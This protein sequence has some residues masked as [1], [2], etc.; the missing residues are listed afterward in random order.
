MVSDMAGDRQL[1]ILI[2]DPHE[3]AAGSLAELLR[4]Y[5]HDATVVR[6]GEEALVSAAESPPDV[7]IVE[8][9]LPDMDGCELAKRMRANAVSRFYCIAVTTSGRPPDRSRSLAAGIVLHLI[10]PVE[11]DSLLNALAGIARLRPEKLK[12]VRSDRSGDWRRNYRLDGKM[13]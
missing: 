8:L 1:S 2:A 6:S 12:Q 3:D 13:T 10:K 5:G 9:R 7:L 11:P 4:L